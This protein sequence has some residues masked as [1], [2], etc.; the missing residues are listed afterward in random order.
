MILKE[1]YLKTILSD[2]RTLSD[3]KIE[4]KYTRGFFNHNNRIADNKINTM[5][6]SAPW[7]GMSKSKNYWIYGNSGWG[8]STAPVLVVE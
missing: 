2:L 1:E 8:K 7:S 4:A 3:Q 5:H 6:L